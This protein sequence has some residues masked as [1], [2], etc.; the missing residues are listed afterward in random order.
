VKRPAGKKV[1]AI[2]KSG[3]VREG[4]LV[5]DGRGHVTLRV[6]PV[7]DR[8]D[9]R[10]DRK[11]FRFEEVS[12]EAAGFRARVLSRQDGS[13]V[14]VGRVSAASESAV[15]VRTGGRAAWYA[16]DLYDIEMS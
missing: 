4:R 1:V 8:E 3:E 10:F 7:L 16:R 5:H 14:R 11:S 9:V 15:K 6:G 12:G 2:G 13:V